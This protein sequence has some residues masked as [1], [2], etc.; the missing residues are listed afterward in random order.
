MF[1][2]QRYL[3]N[4][5]KKYVPPFFLNLFFNNIKIEGILH[6]KVKKFSH[7]INIDKH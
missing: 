4:L 1:D 3:L 5:K 2:L 6:K 7:E